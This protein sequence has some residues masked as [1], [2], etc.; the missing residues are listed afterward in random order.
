[1]ISSTWTEFHSMHSTL[2]QF[3]VHLSCSQLRLQCAS[4]FNL[5]LLFP[6]SAF[7]DSILSLQLVESH[8]S[9]R[10]HPYFNY[11]LF[12]KYSRYTNYPYFHK[13]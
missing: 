4:L 9:P 13:Y 1:M 5:L 3:P 10:A 6:R 8:A 2:L 12:E 7:A 11:H